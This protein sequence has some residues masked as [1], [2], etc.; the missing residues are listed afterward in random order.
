VAISALRRH[1][2]L[3]P[4]N[5]YFHVPLFEAAAGG[6]LLTGVGGDEAFARSSWE[7]PVAVM[8]RQARPV[9]RD[10]L[11][12]GF[13]LAPQALKRKVLSRRV[14]PLAP[15]LWPHARRE[16]EAAL[17]H[18]AASEPVG[19]RNRFRWLLGS[20]MQ[21]VA[22]RSLAVLAADSDVRVSHPFADPCFLAALAALPP[23]RRH[24]SRSEAMLMLTGDDLP[25]M[26]HGRSTKA[27]FGDV[28]FRE[29]S[30]DLVARWQGEGVD[31]SLVDLERL[32][33]EWASPTP[34]SHSFLLLQSAWLAL[35]GAGP[36]RAGDVARALDSRCQPNPPFGQ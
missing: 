28:F 23:G 33:S 16:V 22:T 35:E 8:R 31:P 2:L 13:A 25:P 10:V 19:W 3:W 24:T 29:H 15:W 26:V 14:P 1:G 5:A 4:C 32:A 12:I 36:R 17:V 20:P 9:P 6:S 7:R 21:A 30:R 11:R 27:H 18:L 34:D